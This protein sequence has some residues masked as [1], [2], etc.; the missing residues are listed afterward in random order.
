MWPVKGFNSTAAN[1][2]ALYALFFCASVGLL[3][4]TSIVLVNKALYRQID[5][6]IE[7]EMTELQAAASLPAAVMARV[8][9]HGSLLYRLESVGGQQIAGDLDVTGQGK[10]WSYFIRPE[11]DGQQ[12]SADNFRSLSRPVGAYI[13]TIAE[14]TDEIENINNVLAGAFIIVGI[15]TTILAT[16]GGIW[17]GRFYL[18]RLNQLA[19]TAEEITDGSLALRMPIMPRQSEFNR[20]SQSLNRMLDRNAVL[21]DNQRQITNDIA[22]D[23]RTP[24][25]RLRQKLEAVDGGKM[26]AALEEAD[27]LLVIVDSLLRIAEIEEGS[28]K[29]NFHAL[30][31]TKLATRMEE[32]YAAAFEDQGKQLAVLADETVMV[33]GDAD[34]LTLLLSN[35]LENVLVHAEGASSATIEIRDLAN[36]IFLR[37]TDDGPGIPAGVEEAISRRFYRLDHSRAKPGNGLGLSLVKAIAVLHDA[38]FQL[39]RADPGLSIALVWPKQPLESRG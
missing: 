7:A 29:A 21:L 20:L 38:Q 35:L 26:K 18:R 16:L 34:L 30:N 37:V 11:E 27:G 2:A 23:L 25:T 17:L 6:R 5:S 28:R 39:T 15:I 10:G 9:A 1:L 31:L 12:E 13:L 8:Q 19:A 14:D 32:A 3:G 22:H 33:S 36:E 24:L 4:L